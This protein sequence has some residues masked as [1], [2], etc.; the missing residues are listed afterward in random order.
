[1]N[2]TTYNNHEF[3]EESRCKENQN[4]N[5]HQPCPW[6]FQGSPARELTLLVYLAIS[7]ATSADAVAI[8]KSVLIEEE[9]VLADPELVTIEIGWVLVTKVIVDVEVLWVI[10][11]CC[12]AAKREHTAD[13]S[14]NTESGETNSNCNVYLQRG[15]PI[16][17]ESVSFIPRW[18]LIN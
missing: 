6:K 12:T 11:F 4:P 8:G 18:R 2:K 13:Q 5:P 3:R 16:L 9:S 17:S 10:S 7:A 15:H 14:H 1:M